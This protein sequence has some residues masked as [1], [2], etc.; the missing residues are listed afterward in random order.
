MHS[1]DQTRTC[2]GFTLVELLVVIAVM[3]LI[4]ALVLPAVQASREAARRAVCANNLK[5]IGLALANHHSSLREYPAGMKPD[6]RTK[7]GTL[8]GPPSPISA[9]AQLLP[10]L[11]QAVPFNSLNLFNNVGFTRSLPPEA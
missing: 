4:V 6:G 11:D 2:A 10:Y 5:Q 3:G 8:F 1:S 7:R 9:H